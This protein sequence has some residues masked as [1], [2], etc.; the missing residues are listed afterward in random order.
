MTGVEAMAKTPD[1]H[2]QGSSQSRKTTDP[3]PSK[4]TRWRFASDCYEIENDDTVS[5]S[6]RR[7]RE[8]LPLW[9]DLEPVD[10]AE[11]DGITFEPQDQVTVAVHGEAKPNQSQILL[12]RKLREKKKEYIFL[13]VEWIYTQREVRAYVG[14]HKAKRMLTNHLDVIFLTDVCEKI[15]HF[16]RTPTERVLDILHKP[17][18]I[19][20]HDHEWVSWL[21]PWTSTFTATAPNESLE[22]DCS[23]SPPVVPESQVIEPSSTKQASKEDSTQAH[24][25]SPA[26]VCFM[27]ING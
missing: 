6:V 24:G 19:L 26:S 13:V 7:T 25:M 18:R 4:R 20:P 15:E 9:Q 12:I 27:R 16:Q 5:Y 2:Q 8:D 1:K 22:A 10:S 3:K 11:C 17:A 21:F 23:D 14:K